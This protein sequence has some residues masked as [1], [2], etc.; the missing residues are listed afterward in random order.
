M[1]TL[2]AGLL[3]AGM[4]I[5]ASP[6]SRAGQTDDLWKDPGFQQRFLGTYGVLG[7]MEPR[8]SAAERAELEKI[9]PL[10]A[11]DLA[12]AAEQ[13]KAV[14]TESSSA[15]FDFTLGNIEFQSDRL[16]EAANHYQAAVKKF[17]NFQ[18][19]RASCRERVSYSV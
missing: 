14:T 3:A 12:K 13:L 7:E 1:N 6:A 9:I 5:L 16:D 10:M 11:T 19:G 18:I 8:I 2:R 17:P 4:L 15:L